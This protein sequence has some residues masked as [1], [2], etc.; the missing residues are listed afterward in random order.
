MSKDGSTQT[1]NFRAAC[2][3]Q[4]EGDFVQPNNISKIVE[5]LNNN[6]ITGMQ[7]LHSKIELLECKFDCF[8]SSITQTTINVEELHAGQNSIVPNSWDE[9]ADFDNLIPDIVRQPNSPLTSSF[10]DKK[11]T[12]PVGESLLGATSISPAPFVTSSSSS[13]PG[14]NPSIAASV[15]E[16]SSS[17][18]P[19]RVMFELIVSSFDAATLTQCSLTGKRGLKKFDEGSINIIRNSISTRFGISSTKRMNDIEIQVG[20]SLRNHRQKLLKDKK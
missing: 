18:D 20:I 8:V 4:T 5:N 12:I 14:C 17:Q 11:L 2:A 7:A 10:N 16:S 9:K 3:T 1:E 15:H 19:A 6:F 13:L